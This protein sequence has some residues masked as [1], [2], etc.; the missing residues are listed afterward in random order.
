MQNE[1]WRRAARR[2]AEAEA[3]RA[4]RMARADAVDRGGWK[5]GLGRLGAG[6]W[7]WLWKLAIAVA[8]ALALT[9]DGISA[10]VGVLVE[11]LDGTAGW[12]FGAATAPFELLLAIP[13]A[14]RVLG[15]TWSL[16]L[17][18]LWATLAAP[19]LVM[20]LLGVLP[21]KRLRVWLID[22]EST[23][24]DGAAWKAGF[25]AAALILRREANVRLVPAK[26]F[27]WVRAFNRLKGPSETQWQVAKIGSPRIVDVG[28]QLRAAL[29]D[30]GPLGSWLLWTATRYHLRGGFR[31]L[32]GWGA[33]VMAVAVHSV[34]GGKLAGCSLG[35]LTDYVTVRA[36][37]PV[38]L[39]HELGHACNLLHTN[40]V[41]NL[42]NPTCGGVHLSRWQVAVL[43]LSRH[44]TYL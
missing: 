14:G 38:C 19:E 11:A 36:D 18:L 3:W 27:Q 26:G 12:A 16:F 15:W 21:E 42:M 40:R 23:A 22:P 1:S 30:L 7:L 31:R 9:V 6:V 24:F 32:T 4:E 34:E 28:C 25:E 29:E 39:A 10:A 2:W 44:V 8:T 37:R 13:Y 17:T 33:P 35:P 41:G 43:R 5:A 20:A